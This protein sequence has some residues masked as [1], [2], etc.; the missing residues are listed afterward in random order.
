MTNIHYHLFEIQLRFFYFLLSLLCT[1]AISYNC[2]IEIVYVIGKPFLELHQ[3]FIF[4]E[5]TEA[6][7]TLLQISTILTFLVIGPFL[8]YHFW[9]FLIPSFYGIERKK[10]NSF[11]LLLLCL[12]TCEILF[13]YF[14]LLPKICHFLISFE[15]TSERGASGLHGE[16]MISVEFTARME[17]YVALILKIVS[18][19]LLLFQ[20]P[21]CM[22]FFF[23]KGVLHVSS[24]YTNRKSLGWIS[25]LMSAFLVPPDVVSQLLLALLFLIVFE[26]L[27]FTGLFFEEGLS[28]SFSLHVPCNETKKKGETANLDIETLHPGNEQFKTRCDD[29]I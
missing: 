2:Q 14:F 19:L 4:L 11:C 6:L 25:L 10:I 28:F 16:H 13:A 8:L 3:T 29:S 5:L 15:M 24:L 20:L 7:Y 1:F 26:I 22:F 17:S 21:L 18:S 9:S 12:L 23:S 27:V